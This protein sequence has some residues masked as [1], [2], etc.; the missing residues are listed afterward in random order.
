MYFP[1]NQEQPG[2]SSQ[3]ITQHLPSD[4]LFTLLLPSLK[5]PTTRDTQPSES[6]PSPPQT[7]VK[8]SLTTH[9]HN[10]LPAPFIVHTTIYYHIPQNQNVYLNHRTSKIPQTIPITLAPTTVPFI[11]YVHLSQPPKPLKP[12]WN[13]RHQ[14]RYHLLQSRKP[15]HVSIELT[16]E[17]TLQTPWIILEHQLPNTTSTEKSNHPYSSHPLHWNTNQTLPK[18]TTTSIKTIHLFLIT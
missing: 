16:I 7:I 14:N 1:S 5:V 11:P 9:P 10:H 2:L 13:T 8:P 15:P 4:H 3:P 6:S 12:P 17:A 18:T